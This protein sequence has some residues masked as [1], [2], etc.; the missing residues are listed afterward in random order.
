MQAHSQLSCRCW[1]ATTCKIWPQLLRRQRLMRSTSRT[2]PR[3]LTQSMDA[4][5]HR[6]TKM[7]SRRQKAWARCEQ[8]TASPRRPDIVC[9][10]PDPFTNSCHR[11]AFS[12]LSCSVQTNRTHGSGLGLQA[13]LA[14]SFCG[15]ELEHASNRTDCATLDLRFCFLLQAEKAKGVPV[16]QQL[17]LPKS[18]HTRL[19]PTTEDGQQAAVVYAPLLV[20][21]SH[22]CLWCTGNRSVQD[23]T[24]VIL[25]KSLLYCVL[26]AVLCAV[27]A[28]NI[29]QLIAKP[30]KRDYASD[31][32]RPALTANACRYNALVFHMQELSEALFNLVN[33]LRDLL[34]KLPS[35]A[36]A[37]KLREQGLAA[38]ALDAQHSQ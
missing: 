11:S 22:R 29:S 23:D 35:N 34:N 2:G 33:I 16:D 9:A 20:V 24:C 36:V 13:H 31:S 27:C 32:V 18:D 38:S 1:S 14:N 21:D 37:I 15:C 4:E 19:F 10:Y 8:A 5:R 3:S 26:C 7:R 12:L 25:L 17:G 6:A 28:H 30:Y